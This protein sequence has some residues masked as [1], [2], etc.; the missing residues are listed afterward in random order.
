[1]SFF[2]VCP[3]CVGAEQAYPGMMPY[4]RT[5]GDKS[6]M[7]AVY[8]QSANAAAAAA[9]YQAQALMQLQQPYVPVSCEYPTGQTASAISSTCSS[10]LVTTTSTFSSS[11]SNACSSS[12]SASS[13]SSL[14]TTAP[15]LS[16]V[17]TSAVG[18]VG[19]INLNNP[20]GVNATLSNNF[21]L[22]LTV[23]NGG[24]S[25]DTT[26]SLSGSSCKAKSIGGDEG[27]CEAATSAD[28][29]PSNF[30]ESAVKSSPNPALELH[31]GTQSLGGS[32]GLNNNNNSNN[33]NSVALSSNG[34]VKRPRSPTSSQSNSGASSAAVIPASALA[35]AHLPVAVLSTM[36]T[37][38]PALS[39]AGN[40][41]LSY[42]SPAT[43][44]AALHPYHQ[45]AALQSQTALAYTGVSLN[46]QQHSAL[47]GASASAPSAQAASVG[48]P[49][50]VHAAMQQQY[51][52]YLSPYANL[53]GAQAAQSAQAAFVNS[54]YGASNPFGNSLINGGSHLGPMSLSALSGLSGASQNP[55]AVTQQQLAA[56]QGLQ[57][58]I[59]SNLV[60]AASAGHQGAVGWPNSLQGMY[61]AAAAAAGN[62]PSLSSMTG[63]NQSIMPQYMSLG[64]P[65]S[66]AAVGGLGSLGHA[67]GIRGPHG[68]PTAAG[69]APNVGPSAAAAAAAA[70]AAM[71]GAGLQPYKKM[72]TL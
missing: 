68:V 36:T 42:S 12:S 63:F 7:A 65:G 38:T 54:A 34:G 62:V 45:H 50:S 69:V 27:G 5:A 33:N 64:M 70:A 55:A 2:F 25:Y 31:D 71:A 35:A 4:K 30:C 10:G 23:T 59:N 49:P 53:M 44:S 17:T 16:A 26:V 9:A 14:T 29:A 1:M 11:A 47:V 72:R 3:F 15:S 22:G 6:G 58:Q 21:S 51:Q 28:P 61:A 46:K 32:H 56:L 19:A 24:A 37:M 43:S 18:G 8:Q 57:S 67:H 40:S 60:A 41:L 39:V 66:A 52:Q 13:S 48:F 20:P